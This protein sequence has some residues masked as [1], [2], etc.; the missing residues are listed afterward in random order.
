MG[1]RSDRHVRWGW[2]PFRS[3]RPCPSDPS[4]IFLPQIGFHSLRP[5]LPSRNPFV[6]FHSGPFD[7]RPSRSKH[8][9]S[10]SFVRSLRPRDET[11][12]RL[13]NPVDPLPRVS[14]P[15]WLLTRETPPTAPSARPPRGSSPQARQ[16]RPGGDRVDQQHAARARLPGRGDGEGVGDVAPAGRAGSSR[17]C[18][19]CRGRGRRRPQEP[20][21]AD[22]GRAVRASSQTWLA[23]ALLDRRGVRRGPGRRRRARAALQKVSTRAPRAAAG[24]G[25]RRTSRGRWRERANAV[26][27]ATDTSAGRSIGDRYVLRGVGGAAVGMGRVAGHTEEA[28]DESKVGGEA[29]KPR[30]AVAVKL[31][32]QSSGTAR[33]TARRRGASCVRLTQC[34]R[35]RINRVMKS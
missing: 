23:A 26:L 10:A 13:H 7:H 21:R 27:E 14:A 33:R 5:A 2:C 17:V 29:V 22:A 8:H 32:G 24:W 9:S 15:A 18:G 4:L 1:D 30:R 6:P 11:P 25:R 3:I 35:H 20:P 12:P 28:S 31:H 34:E 19:A 16:R